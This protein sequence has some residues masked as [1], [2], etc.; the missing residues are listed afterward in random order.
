VAWQAAVASPPP[1]PRANHCLWINLVGGP[2]QLETW[3]PKPAA[4][5][6]I[7]GPFDPIATRVPGIALSEVFPGL[8][9]RADRFVLL[10]S[11]YHDAA[12]IHETGFQFLQTGNLSQLGLSAP[13]FGAALDWS[14][15]GYADQPLSGA[16]RSVLLPRPLGDT[17]V[18]VGHG[19]SAGV[20]GP[21][22]DLQRADPHSPADQ[23]PTTRRERR[24]YGT[25]PLGLSCLAARQWL[26]RGARSVTLNM[27]ETVFHQVTWDAH[28]N[29]SDLPATLAAYRT[30]L[31]PQLDQALSALLDDLVESGLLRET[32]L[33]VTGEFGRTPKLNRRGG[34]DHW[35]GCWTA[36]VA[37][38]GIAGGRVLGSSDATASSPA[39]LPIH[40]SRLAATVYHALGVDRFAPLPI[41]GRTVPLCL[42]EPVTQL[43]S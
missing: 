39:D 28:A 9:A 4:P 29:G 34:R 17:G 36:L 37:G 8:A 2:S 14:A 41:P 6:E 18:Q 10:R 42:A 33:V 27:F 21:A 30:Q 3:D 26:E 20:L 31:G 11:L 43:W 22:W 24:L 23:L 38:A 1:A 19:Q 12:P 25:S 7:R 35:P 15:S 40:A 32:L 5:A 16:A 13:H